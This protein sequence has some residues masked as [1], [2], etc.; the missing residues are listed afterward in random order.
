MPTSRPSVAS[1][2]TWA[3][4]E[5]AWYPLLL[6]ATTPFFLQR[7]GAEQYG[8][9]MLTL[10]SIGLGGVLSAGTTAATVREVAEALGRGDRASAARR[11]SAG[12][13]LAAIGGSVLVGLLLAVHGLAG[14][15][16]LG[17]M[18]SPALL[19][20][21]AAAA[22]ALLWLEQF[23]S[24]CT[25]ALRGA[26]RFALAAGIEV[27]SKTLQI[28][29]GVLAVLVWPRLWM[30]YCVLG[31]VALL[32][33]SAKVLAVRHCFPGQSLRPR[34]AGAA[35]LFVLAR[36]G[37]VQGVGGVLF[38]VADR[39]LIGGLLGASSLAYYAI[40]TQLSQQVHAFAAAACSA[41]LPA[42]SRAQVSSD[43]PVVARGMLVALCANAAFAIV[44]AA[45]VLGAGP[46]LVRWWLEPGAAEV[47]TGLLPW[48]VLAYFLLA[49]NAA[50]H[51]L[52]LSLGRFRYVSL[53]NLSAGIVLAILLP[54]AIDRHGLDGV[55]MSRIVYGAIIM[56]NAWPLAKYIAGA[57]RG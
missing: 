42:M 12:L 4:L 14:E 9:W 23:D 11:V 33:L 49:L 55:A 18:G 54:W 43:G 8:F 53:T 36:W 21:S 5:H 47:V 32:R 31:V 56:A 26:E 34:I 44:L 2:A 6:F 10:A 20:L 39:L 57:R 45:L 27:V 37:W 24:V 17:R 29:S 50:P 48:L 40:A 22:A 1:N 16:L 13:A 30:L 7:L 41:L 3:L 15:R 35:S 25:A 38:G 28:A 19:G 46:A 51:F 52:L